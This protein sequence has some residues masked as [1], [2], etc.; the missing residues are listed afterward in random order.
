VFDDLWGSDPN[1]CGTIVKHLFLDS[2]GA[3]V[4]T[5]T[6]TGSVFDGVTELDN[7]FWQ[8]GGPMFLAT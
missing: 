1:V 3:K 5:M 2:A 8:F 7:I 6:D 4:V